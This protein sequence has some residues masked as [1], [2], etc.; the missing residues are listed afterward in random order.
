MKIGDIVRIKKC[1]P[2][3][4]VIGESAEIASL[5][6]QEFEKYTVYPIW[7]KMVTGEHK[8]KIYGFHYDEVEVLTR[9]H[10]EEKVQTELVKQLAKLLKGVT[11][12]ENITEV[13]H[14]INEAKG[15]VL[16]EVA[17]G[18][19]EDKTPCWEMF[20][21]PEFVK[22]ECPAFKYRTL[23]C[24][25][26]EGTY[27]KALNQETEVTGNNICQACRVYQRWGQGKPIEIR[28]NSKGVNVHLPEVSKQLALP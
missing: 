3:P 7:G 2:L 15:K 25:Q 11:T 16:A 9:P 24:W 17:S 13:E 28:L 19:W 10:K 20:C 22:N 5:Q 1:N 26:I 8:G 27:C 23:P 6:T 12:L 14:I 18:Y 4:E 21:C